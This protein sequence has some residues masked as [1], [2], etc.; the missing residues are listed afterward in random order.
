MKLTPIQ[1]RIICI[2]SKGEYVKSGIIIPDLD[3]TQIE[4]ADVVAVGPGKYASDG[5][6]I[7]MQTRLGDRI[8]F[9]RFQAQAVRVPGD[10]TDYLALRDTD[11][12]AVMNR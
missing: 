4:E 6:R 2:K 10:N 12:R 1:D 9:N 11:V 3:S 7:P 5:T 8:V